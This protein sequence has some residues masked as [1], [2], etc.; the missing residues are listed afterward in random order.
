MAILECEMKDSTMVYGRLDDKF[1]LP[2]QSIKGDGYYYMVVAAAD[3]KAYLKDGWVE[4][5][6][7]L[8]RKKRAKKTPDE[9]IGAV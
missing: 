8:V 6:S 1:N 4:E 2:G 9:S 5:P 3:V 7:K